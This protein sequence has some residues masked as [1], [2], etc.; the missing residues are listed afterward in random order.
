LNEIHQS[1]DQ[2]NAEQANQRKLDEFRFGVIHLLSYVF[3]F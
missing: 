2:T 3:L 1:G